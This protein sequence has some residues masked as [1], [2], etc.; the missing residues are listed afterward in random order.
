MHIFFCF[1]R[2]EF[3]L[4]PPSPKP[5]CG[6]GGE[7][8]CTTCLEPP[9]G[10]RHTPGTNWYQYCITK[11]PY[12]KGIIQ[13]TFIFNHK[14]GTIL[15]SKYTYVMNDAYPMYK[16]NDILHLQYTVPYLNSTFNSNIH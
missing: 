6:N 7:S 4:P 12:L 3:C 11:R 16:S 15:C 9:Y 1:V 2:P 14:L 10:N 8:F 13:Y 5:V